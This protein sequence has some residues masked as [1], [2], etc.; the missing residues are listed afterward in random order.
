MLKDTP[1][2]LESQAVHEW[3]HYCNSNLAYTANQDMKTLLHVNQPCS[4][5]TATFFPYNLS[6]LS[7][8]LTKS[9]FPTV[10]N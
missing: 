5:N 8:Q 3:G 2:L 6:Y 10:Y 1:V 7:Q 9:H 4:G